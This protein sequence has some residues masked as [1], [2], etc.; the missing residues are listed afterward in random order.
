MLMRDIRFVEAAVGDLADI[1]LAS[2][3]V[4]AIEP[5]SSLQAPGNIESAGARNVSEAE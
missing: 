3:A 5:F 2:V 1:V 4:A